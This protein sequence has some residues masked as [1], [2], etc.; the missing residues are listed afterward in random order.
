MRWRGLLRSR[1]RPATEDGASPATRFSIL[2]DSPN[3]GESD[4]LGSED[5]ARRLEQLIV[6]SQAS[7]PFT[8]SVEAGW[9]A[10]KSTVMRRI[11][12][13]FRGMAPD[14]KGQPPTGTRTV[15]F[16]A[17]TAPESQVLEGLVRSVLDQLDSN[18]LR[19]VAR[20][21]K[22]LRGMG[23]GVSLA[24]GLLGLGNVVDRLWAKAS[25]DPKQRNE[26]NDFVR[27]AMRE[28]L[29]KPSAPASRLIVVFIDDLDRCSST[30]VLRVFEAMKLYLDAPGFVF[31]VGWDTEQVARAVA[32]ERAVDPGVSQR[33][34]E[35]IVQF[36]FRI[37]RSTPEQLE[38][39]VDA[40]CE[41]AGLSSDVL[42]PA[43]RKLLLRT[44]DGNPRQLKRF[45]NRFILLHE[46]LGSGAKAEALILLL[47]LQ[48]SYDGFYRLLSTVPG[49]DDRDNPL[50]EFDDYLEARQ[51]LA[52][53]SWPDLENAL[54]RRGIN[55]VPISADDADAYFNAFE[56]N[57]P[58]DYQILA[59]DRQFVGLLTSMTDDD[60]RQL[61][62]LARSDTVVATQAPDVE[63]EPTSSSPGSEPMPV[64]L[65]STVLWIDDEPKSE[66]QALLPEDVQLVV[67][68]SQAEAERIMANARRVDL[69]I[70]DIGRGDDPNAGLDG[71]RQLRA[72]GYDGPAVFY[73]M[74]PTTGNVSEANSLNAEVMAAPRELKTAIS[75]H[76]TAQSP[77]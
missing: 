29:D 22:M 47:V 49:D 48:S 41:E 58:P 73:T 67:A 27:D 6:G 16:N 55:A 25:V 57:L 5:V 64:E 60:K 31:V 72:A 63:A 45:I 62:A 35:K 74:R 3:L 68:T 71:L 4:P 42:D 13:R 14:Q 8:V 34:V 44:T 10:G 76:L 46:L 77:K 54:T 12:R 65:G 61:R 28:W 33:Y 24:A 2:S 69:V 43:H 75:R 53:R 7:T 23:I 51:A 52:R 66:D 19:S 37:P 26:L 20:Q 36:G 38:K 56:Q 15:W 59:T 32:A 18:I 21:K 11:E 17:W 1:R 39:L 30:T 50:V 40:C 9:G 70:S